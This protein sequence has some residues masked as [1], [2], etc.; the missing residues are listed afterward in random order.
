MA[1]ELACKCKA[2]GHRWDEPQDLPME[3]GDWLKQFRKIKCPK[4]GAGI[5]Q[6]TLLFGSA[7]EKEDWE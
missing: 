6:I 5:K 7:L 4:C 3:V 2:C 1:N